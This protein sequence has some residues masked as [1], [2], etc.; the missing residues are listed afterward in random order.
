M[1]PVPLIQMTLN[2]TALIVDDEPSVRAFVRVIL[3]REGF[4]TIEAEGGKEAL[5]AVQRLDGRLN[6]IV[7][8]IHMPDGDGLSFARAVT[9]C[10]PTVPIVVISGLAKP[11]VGFE[12]VEKPFAWATLVHA[13]RKVTVFQER[14]A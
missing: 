4:H 3:E 1:S 13:I 10:F 9:V 6:L 12:F 7:T 14:I 5:A 8:D 2:R 11:D